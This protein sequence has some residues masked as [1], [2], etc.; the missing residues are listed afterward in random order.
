MGCN[1][2]AEQSQYISRTVA[3]LGLDA[4]GKSSIVHQMI[5]TNTTEEYIPIPTAGADYFETSLSA[6]KFCIYDCGGIG[7]YRDGW[8][9]YIKQSDAV[10]FVID[11]TDKN[12]M[13][14]VRDEIQIVLRKCQAQQIPIL[15]LINKSDKK[16]LLSI[17][18]FE[19]ITGIHDFKVEYEI[20][21]C[22]ALS[23]DTII[24]ARDWLIQH[25]KPRTTITIVESK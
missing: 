9:F 23:A 4:S 6:S 8:E 15:I 1:A 17:N 18:D 11:R 19:L 25:V 3:F 5:T 22:S 13:S 20:K 14:V 16:S 2:T 10:C 21:E 12:R 24:G 7:R